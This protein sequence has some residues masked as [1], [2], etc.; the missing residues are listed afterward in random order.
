MFEDQQPAGTQQPASEDQIDDR[1]AARK[2]IRSVRKND[3]ELLGA[4][5]QVEKNIRLDGIEVVDPELSG[6]AADEIVVHRVD[7]DRGD[8]PRSPRRKLVAD[9]P[10]PGKEVEDVALLEI[11][12]V[13]QHV[14][15]ILLGKI[16]RRPGPQVAGRI[17]RPSLVFSADYSHRLFPNR[18]PMG[19]VI[20]PPSQAITSMNCPGALP[21]LA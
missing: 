3:V 15:E 9:R 6:R 17:D 18:F 16:G 8:T 7:L 19:P 11:D 10:R 21:D 2:V 20:Q 14:E 4:A 1:L 13:A 12:Q 5:P